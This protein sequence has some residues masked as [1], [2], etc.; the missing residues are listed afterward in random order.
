MPAEITL[1]FSTLFGFLR[2]LA[3]VS[4][5]VAFLPLAGVRNTPDMARITLAL[6]ITICLAP[7]WP[8]LGA[9]MNEMSPGAIAAAVALETAFGLATGVVVSF[10]T[11]SFQVGA[12]IL[13]LQAGYSYAS[14][15]DPNSQAD[16]G[17][18]QLLAQLIASVLFFTL[19]FEREVIRALAASLANEHPG[20]RILSLAAADL[21]MRAGAD[22]LI[23]G[24]RVAL[25]V[26][27]LL[28][29]VDIALALL[30]RMQAQL[31]L[32]TVAF[33]AKMLAALAV[34]AAI[35]AVLPHVFEVAGRRSMGAIARL[36]GGM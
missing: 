35:V 13:G 18:L 12:Q 26:V 9:G 6:A 23:T 34:F 31:Q 19:G 27:A 30:G 25:P 10:L 4:G 20:S 2:A 36:L 32:L 14:T 3:R 17:V 33:P 1:S 7:A 24:L 15:I 5:V 8:I 29:M 22:M 11:E 16:T 28:L 21:M